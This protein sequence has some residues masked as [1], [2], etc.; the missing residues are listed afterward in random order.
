MFGNK[1]LELIPSVSDK[2]SRTHRP[3][4]QRID[5]AGRCCGR[6][7]RPGILRS[8]R[9]QLTR[10][11]WERAVPAA[12]IRE[13]SMVMFLQ[14]YLQHQAAAR[15]LDAP[16]LSVSQVATGPV[17]RGMLWNTDTTPAVA[18]LLQSNSS[19]NSWN[20]TPKLKVVP[21]AIML[22]K[23]DAATTTQP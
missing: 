3:P 21:S 13:P 5:R 18:A 19:W 12:A 20:I 10:G 6:R 22:T 9:C 8:G 7:L 23:K 1:R 4:R 11:C 14:P 16:H 15:P 17:S 2:A